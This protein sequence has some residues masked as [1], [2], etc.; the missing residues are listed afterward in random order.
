MEKHDIK[1]KCLDLA[2]RDAGRVG[3]VV[4]QVLDKAKGFYEWVIEGDTEN[5]VKKTRGRSKKTQR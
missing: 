4:S 5:Q 1:L 2:T 3:F